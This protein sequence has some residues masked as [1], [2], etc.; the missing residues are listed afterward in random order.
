M[1]ISNTFK[2]RQ[3]RE[4]NYKQHVDVA[5]GNDFLYDHALV[6]DKGEV[7]HFI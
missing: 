4:R 6:Q 7:L 3:L 1:H 2:K 5:A